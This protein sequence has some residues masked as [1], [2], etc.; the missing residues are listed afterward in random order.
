MVAA[1]TGF[2]LLWT[3]SATAV[4]FLTLGALSGR[5]LAWWAA[6]G[7][8]GALVGQK[9]IRALIT[10]TGRPSIVTLLLATLSARAPRE[11]KLEPR[12]PASLPISIHCLPTPRPHPPAL[13]A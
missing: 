4:N 10:R 2:M 8:F 13:T 11:R 3:S 1:T 6:L 9:A 7:G 5:I 12:P